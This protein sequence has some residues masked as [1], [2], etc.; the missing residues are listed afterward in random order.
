MYIAYAADTQV[1][2]ANYVVPD[3]ENIN[4]NFTSFASQK[5]PS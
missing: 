1:S 4:H 2:T 5:I 3:Q